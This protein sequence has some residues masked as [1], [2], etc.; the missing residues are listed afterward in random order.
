MRDLVARYLDAAKPL[1]VVDIG[2]YDVNGSYRTLFGNPA[3][4]YQ[5]VDLEAGP[6]VDIVLKSPYCLPFAS[7]RRPR[8]FRAGFRA[9]RIF[10]DELDGDAADPQAGRHDLPDRAIERARAP[11]SAGLLAFLSGWIPGVGEIR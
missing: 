11:L 1:R 4:S 10:L 5:G 8:C 7:I 9:R 2:S 3:W 6:G